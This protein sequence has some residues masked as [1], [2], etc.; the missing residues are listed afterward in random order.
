LAI[1]D[2]TKKG[3][4]AMSWCR[5]VVVSQSDT[6]DQVASGTLRAI[7]AIFDRL[8]S[9]SVTAKIAAKVTTSDRRSHKKVI[10]KCS[11]SPSKT[12]DGRK[13]RKETHQIWS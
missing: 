10:V 9:P 6:G 3:D 12:L 4:F 11:R 13:L 2:R 1:E 8:R 7:K 5:G